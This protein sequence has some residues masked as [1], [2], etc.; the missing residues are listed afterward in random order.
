MRIVFEGRDSSSGEVRA[1]MPSHL[2]LFSTSCWFVLDNATSL[3]W[4]VECVKVVYLY[5]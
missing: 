4:C 5:R 3:V 1:Y 2:A